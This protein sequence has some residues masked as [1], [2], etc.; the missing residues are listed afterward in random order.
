MS[1]ERRRDRAGDRP[2]RRSG[3]GPRRD[4]TRRRTACATPTGPPPW[5]ARGAGGRRART[6]CAPPRSARTASTASREAARTTRA[7]RTVGGGRAAADATPVVTITLIA[8]NVVVFVLT[9]LSAGSAWANYT[10]A[11]GRGD[12]ARARRRRGRPVVAA[13]DRGLPAH[14]SAARRV[15][16]VR[17]VGARAG[18]SSSCS[19]GCASRCS[20]GSRCSA[21]RRRSCCSATPDRPVAGASGAVFGLM[22][23]L[24][25]VLRRLAALA[26]ARRC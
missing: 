19:D 13:G 15:Q 23:A 14:R 6:A 5:P 24:V 22:G 21:A 2:D 11:V 16:H 9:A 12:L 18:T 8:V 25:V 10:L 1:P 20:T 7:P 26:D 3:R 4:R 17:A